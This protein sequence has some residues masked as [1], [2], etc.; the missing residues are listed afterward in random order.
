MTGLH[1]RIILMLTLPPLLWAGNAV[2]GRLMVG[3]VPPL[4]LNALR[5]S[6]A[7]VLLLPLGWRLFRRPGDLA[8]RLRYLA[9]LSLMGVG[10]YNALQ[11]MAVTTSTPINVTLIAASSPLFMLAVGALAYGEHP[12][13]RQGTGAVLSLLGVALVLS[14]GHPSTLLQLHLVPG[15]LLMLLATALWAVYS[16]M[17]ARPPASMRPPER[18]PWS[19]AEFL[20]AQVGF[21]ALWASAGAGAEHAL[22]G[23]PIVWS[24]A[25]Y[26]ALAY[27]A[28]GPSIV[29]Y[30]CWGAGVTAVGPAVAAFFAN[31]TPVFA[32]LMSAAMLGE[33]PQWYHVAAFGLIAA[34]IVVTSRAAPRRTP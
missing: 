12:T 27:V 32:A 4:A 17:L 7:F 10:S 26:A 22:A 33:G 21:G 34:G 23:Q 30:F 5:W 15:D 2:V 13:R 3:S 11:Y 19:G 24:G 1:P 9:P 6:L 8:A 28:I 20:L 18:P 31:L 14:H 25:V 16:W 29:A